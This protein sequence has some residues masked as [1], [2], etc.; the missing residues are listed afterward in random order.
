MLKNYFIIAWRTLLA[1]R[2]YTAINIFGLTVGI[3]SCLVIYLIVQFELSFNRTIADADRIYRVYTT[4]SGDF[5]GTNRGVGTGVQEAVTQFNGLEAAVP[6]QTWSA[7]VSLPGTDARSKDDETHLIIVQPEYFLL[8]SAY[9]WKRG[10]ADALKA[11]LQVVLELSQA[12]KYFGTDDPDQVIGKTLHYNDSLV[13]TVAGL[14]SRKEG[15]TDFEFTDF[16]SYS[17]IEASWLKERFSPHDWQ[18]TNSSSQL[19]I[20][21]SDGTAKAD[22]EKQMLELDKEYKKHSTNS[23]FWIVKYKLQPLSDLHYNAELGIFDQS[24]PAAH[25]S[26]LT[27]LSLVALVLLTM[28]SINFINLETARAVKRAREVGIRKVMG[29]TRAQ[30]IRHFLAQSVLLALVAVL[31]AIPAAELGLILFDDFVPKGVAF[32]LT[33]FATV[34]FLIGVVFVVGVLSG[35]YPAFVLSSF[36]PAIAL[37]N[38]GYISSGNSR[39]AYMRKGL[40]VFQ[41]ASAQLLII[42]TLVIISQINFMLDK[43]LGFSQDAVIH[44]QPPWDASEEKRFVLKNELERVPGIAKLSLC[45]SP[46]AANG[47]SSNVLTVKRNGEEVR[48]SVMRKFGDINY[49]EVYGIQLVAGRNLT[50]NHKTEILVN[51]TFLK[52]FGLN[53]QDALGQEVTQHER[54]YTIV[55]IM[56][57]YHVFS[58]HAPYSPVYMSG[59]EEELYAMSVKIS[60][61]ESGK[62]DFKPVLSDMEAAWKK[63]YPDKNFSYNFVDETIR[64]F[65]LSEKRMSRLAATA[66]TIAIVI[67]CLGLF[68]LV[69]FTSIQRS[70]EVGIRKVLGATAQN[71]LFL[72]SSDFIR[73]VAIAFLIAVP[74]S[75][76]MAGKFLEDYTFHVTPGVTLYLLAGLGSVILAFLTVSYQALKT[77]FMNPVESLRID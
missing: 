27:T 50:P 17:T 13:L 47:Y 49:L 61:P 32:S 53:Q 48:K 28:A 8:N 60:R 44:V 69:S 11:P 9:E 52:E 70:K 6:F 23:G 75:W 20:K 43:D 76:W 65:Y 63:V 74:V 15:N 7:K 59:L 31:L 24:R 41:F 68:G 26:T 19:W 5:E 14:V 34:G 40:I 71:I 12:R 29:S 77:S 3:S 22:I 16:I 62:Y 42:G 39:S 57:D 73:L 10:S 64:N 72:L 1:N 21:L 36:L 45:Q 18:S 30:L 54:V 33:E 46:P 35:L 2:L 25:L 66:M 4:F 56:K 67:S 38:Q 37:K 55:G 58:L 51:E